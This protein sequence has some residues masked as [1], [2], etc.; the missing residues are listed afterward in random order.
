MELLGP[1]NQLVCY[2]IPEFQ[3]IRLH[4]LH[5]VSP[6]GLG[7]YWGSCNGLDKMESALPFLQVVEL[8]LHT[9]FPAM[10]LQLMMKVHM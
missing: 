10:S 1:M 7:S 8:P 6:E 9:L 2:E 4:E 5:E 3:E